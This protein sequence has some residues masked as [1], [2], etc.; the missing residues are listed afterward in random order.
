M[1]TSSLVLVWKAEVLRS[2]NKTN[3][4]I[5]EG[6]I[7]QEGMYC[8]VLQFRE[9]LVVGCFRSEYDLG[10]ISYPEIISL[11]FLTTTTFLCSLEICTVF[12]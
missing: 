4:S 11:F 7:V 1:K 6:L 12:L 5:K 3:F 9:W 10:T 8:Y 2:A